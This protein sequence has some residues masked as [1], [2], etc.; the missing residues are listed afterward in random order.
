MDE[1]S[2]DIRIVYISKTSELKSNF[3]FSELLAKY[4]TCEDD[5]FAM[6]LDNV[7]GLFYGTILKLTKNQRDSKD[8]YQEFVLKMIGVP[9]IHRGSKF[10]AVQNIKA[11]LIMTAKNLAYDYLKGQSHDLPSELIDR[12]IYISDVMNQEDIAVFEEKLTQNL[13]LMNDVILSMDDELRNFTEVYLANFENLNN[14]DRNAVMTE[15]KIDLT[16]Y[17]RLFERMKWTLKKHILNTL[18]KS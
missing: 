6:L 17:K 16:T 18:G 5:E 15:M 13:K 10:E 2:F 1:I 14:A 3:S 4:L 9:C 7:S 11:Y 8:I 12:E